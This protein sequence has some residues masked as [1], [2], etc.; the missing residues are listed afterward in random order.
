MV[1]GS[2]RSTLAAGMQALPVGR[3]VSDVQGRRNINNEALLEPK[4]IPSR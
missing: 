3:R 4:S 1:E 2:E